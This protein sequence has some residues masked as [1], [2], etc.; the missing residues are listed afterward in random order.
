MVGRSP[1]FRQLAA[2]P[3]ARIMADG[4]EER[5]FGRLV[6]LQWVDFMRYHALD[7]KY[8]DLYGPHV[9]HFLR[10]SKDSLSLPLHT[11]PLHYG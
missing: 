10:A 9:S 5:D 2:V 1:I 7:M 6:G 8:A 4:A 11:L 3:T